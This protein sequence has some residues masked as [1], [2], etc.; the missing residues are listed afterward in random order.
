VIYES[1]DEFYTGH[2]TASAT[3]AP[4]VTAANAHKAYRFVRVRA[5]PTNTGS[6]YVGPAGVSTV[7]GYPLAAGE[8]VEIPVNSPAK[9]YVVS[10]DSCEFEWLAI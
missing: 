9:V 2:G 6:V 5:L 1:V 4:L 8:S 7:T 10:S 3:A